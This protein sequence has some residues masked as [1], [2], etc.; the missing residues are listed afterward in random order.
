[1]HVVFDMDGV[2]LDSESDL[3]WLDRALNE[4][5]DAFDL[6]QT[7]AKRQLLYP[8]NL[9]DFDE[10]AAELG[11]PPAELW[12]VRHEA[13]VREK[14]RA[15]RD[16]TI[17]PFEDLEMLGTLAD[18]AVVSI[19]SNSPQTVVETFIEEAALGSVV[20]TG[21]GRGP[22]RD[23]V[24]RMKPATAMYDQLTRAVPIEPTVYVGDT[25]S[26]ALFAQRTGMEFVHL[27]RP[28]GPVNS[29][30]AVIERIRETSG[31]KP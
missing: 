10:A 4:T 23:A 12:P 28:D 25:R 5:L 20:E 6:A 29:L 15:L 9:R 19:V 31:Q 24:E 21:I 3:S 1:M 18:E 17:G 11:V 27:D 8:P 16:G 13:Y 26:D 22:S 2:L 14:E 30:E 7:A